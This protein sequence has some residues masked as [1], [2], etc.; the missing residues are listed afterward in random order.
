MKGDS[1]NSRFLLTMVLLC[2]V[3]APGCGK[4]N[5]GDL[6]PPYYSSGDPSDLGFEGPDDSGAYTLYGLEAGT[7]FGSDV[8]ALAGSFPSNGASDVDPGALVALRFNK[9]LRD[10]VALLA[11]AVTI[12]KSS[13]GDNVSGQWS[14]ADGSAHKTTVFEPDDPLEELTAYEVHIASNLT[15][16]QGMAY[17]SEQAAV[18][19]STGET[20]GN[21][22]FTLVEEV[23]LP[24]PSSSTVSERAPV[25]IFF[26]EAVDASGGPAGLGGTSANFAISDQDGAPIDGE[27]DFLYDN[28]LFVFY[29]T[30]SMPAGK[31]IDV[32]V[33]K[34]TGNLLGDET[35]DGDFEFSFDIVAFPR[36]TS[37][38]FTDVG[39]PFLA[40][41]ASLYTG[42]IVESNL[43]S[44]EIT[45]TLEGSGQSDTLTLILWDNDSKAIIISDEANRSAGPMTYNVDVQPKLTEAIKDGTVTVG[46][47]TTAKSGLNSPVGPPALL[48]DLLKDL[49]DPLLYSLGPPH[50]SAAGNSELLLD[51]PGAGLHGRATEDLESITITVDV[52]GTP[53]VV[54]GIA[55]FSMEYPS[56]SGFFSQEVTRGGGNLF[57]TEPLAGIDLDLVREAAPFRVTEVTLVDLAGNT[58]ILVDPT[59]TTVDYVGFVDSVPFPAMNEIEI[60]CYDAVSLRPV[61]DADVIVDRHSGDYASHDP[62]DRLG[63]HTGQ[64]GTASFPM[65]SHFPGDYITVTAIRDGYELTSLLGIDK[66]LGGDGVQL[67]LP[68]FPDN[69]ASAEA[70]VTLAIADLDGNPLPRVL[71]GGNELRADDGTLFDAGDDPSSAE[72]VTAR[73]TLQFL[74]AIGVEASTPEDRYQWAW[75]N[76]YLADSGTSVQSALFTEALKGVADLPIQPLLV[77]EPDFTELEARLVA[78]LNGF[79]GTLPLAVDL[80]GIASGADYDFVV[81]LPPSLFVNERITDL[82]DSAAFDPPYELVIEPALGPV[83]YTAD[84]SQTLLEDSL[85]FE[86]EERETGTDPR[87][88]AVRIPYAETNI[89]TKLDVEFPDDGVSSVLLDVSFG[90]T[91]HPPEVSWEPVHDRT[92]KD[93]IYRLRYFTTSGTRSWN[94]FVPSG[95]YSGTAIRFPDLAALPAG[96]TALN[97][98]DDFNAPG[99]YSASAEAYELTGF[100]LNAAFL[101]AVARDWVSYYK[102]GTAQATSTSP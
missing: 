101:S 48:P 77:K 40:L 10:S 23:I 25:L 73:N 99:D 26:S 17:T 64:D 75:S 87:I 34:E 82:P 39:A 35:L 43:H 70:T 46:A 15:D 21:V 57:I 80:S 95:A 44:L 90:D 94:A 63:G 3:L 6:F 20:G 92:G 83:D 45:V 31:R 24:A 66:P 33:K 96:F 85:R 47:F 13:G 53:Q 11:Q 102:S 41:P 79:R 1:L 97:A 56:G 2:L 98:L 67:S 69:T 9:S 55:F 81:P 51:E 89:E 61:A 22:P 93:G 68:L 72:V 78:R 16:A 12:K 91:A 65:V 60:F 30:V 29:P 88:V 18:A 59:D 50:G 86:V 54:E 49:E 36:V 74:E 71:I 5:L 52:N 19:F 4:N 58:T 84:P 14:F 100:D 62:A 32:T 8:L 28:R 37:I 38:L 7:I 27:R 42:S 76:P